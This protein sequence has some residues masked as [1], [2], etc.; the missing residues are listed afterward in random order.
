M[1]HWRVAILAVAAACTAGKDCSAEG[2]RDAVLIHAPSGI[3]EL[4]TGALTVCIEGEC[5]DTGFSDRFVEVSSE[6]MEEGDEV[7]A[8]LVMPDGNRFEASVEASRNRPNGPGCSP[9][10][11]D[12]ELRLT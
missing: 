6:N 1:L 7:T 3:A 5:Q 2:C 8:V 11:I 12:A 4:T 9:V 10:C